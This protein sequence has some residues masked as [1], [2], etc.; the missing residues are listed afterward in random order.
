[1]NRIL[2]YVGL[3]VSLGGIAYL[4]MMPEMR[5]GTAL[6][7]FRQQCKG[8]EACAQ[9]LETQRRISLDDDINTRA[10]AALTSQDAR[11]GR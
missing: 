4:A 11:R 9:K 3:A 6:D 2:L 7:G 8:D 5:F 1:M 10:K